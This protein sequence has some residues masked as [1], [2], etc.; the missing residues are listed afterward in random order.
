M[1]IAM[2]LDEYSNALWSVT[3]LAQNE[4]IN[5]SLSEKKRSGISKYPDQ[6]SMA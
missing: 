3:I 4:L 6:I 1:Q 5:E 2:Q